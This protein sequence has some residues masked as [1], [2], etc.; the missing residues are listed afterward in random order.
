MSKPNGGT[1]EIVCAPHPPLTEYYESEGAR[2]GWVR[3]M[4]DKTA[5]D[6]DWMEK[7]L[8]FGTG[9][10]YRHEA[11]LRAGLKPG[12]HAL[13]V[14]VG[15][16]LVASQAA[17]IV[18]DPARVAGVDPSPGMLENAKVP[19]GVQLLEGSAE[20]IP[21]PDATFDFLSMGY[22]LRHI[23]DLSMAFAEFY[24]VLK[25]GGRICI[26]EIT[27]P[28][29]RLHTFCLKLYLRRIVPLFAT[30]FARNR[31]TSTL[32]RYYWDTIEACAAPEDVL[33]TLAQAGF[34][35]VRRGVELGMFSEY[36]AVKP[37]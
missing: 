35:Q 33:H 29:G 27:R 30:V 1:G 31:Q 6:Y 24:R 25:P 12:M 32:W 2:R 9:G 14:G 23:S 34:G 8:G 22:A 3:G 37:A 21:F 7:V 20:H 28:E 16:G 10:W 4:F 36:Q 17:R 13:D 15:T 18:G 11:L 26:L 5:C 19:P